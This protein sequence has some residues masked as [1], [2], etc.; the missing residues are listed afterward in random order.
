MSKTI[1]MIH[2]MWG[3]PWCWENYKSFFG[4]KG[5]QCLT[6]ALRH[7]DIDPK[8]SPNPALGTTSLLD[9]VQDLEE[10]ICSL[11]EKPIIMG[12]S[13]GGLLAQILGA[14]GLASKLVLI[15]PASPSGIIAMKF[16]V[17]KSFWGIL[18]RWGFWRKPNRI[19][20][21]AASYSILNLVSEQDRK[22]AFETAVY[23]SGRAAAEVGFWFFD[24]K[25]ASKVDE[26]QITCPVLVIGGTEDRIVPASVAC[27]IAKKYE[28]VSKYKEFENHAHWLFGEA[29]WQS[30]AEYIYGWIK[31]TE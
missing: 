20:Y 17:I 6:P 21:R 26:S 5:Y 7:H 14:K 27:K 11:D 2:G 28:R 24:F 1:V 16:S 9:Y 25:G 3:G 19:S 10:F 4:D 22:A 12:H 30:I 29:G 15:T 8:D 18:T 31:E 13:M 23:E